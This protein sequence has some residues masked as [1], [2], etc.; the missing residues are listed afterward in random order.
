AAALDDEVDE[1]LERPTLFG[2]GVPPEG[3]ELEGAVGLH[4]ADPVEVLEPVRAGEGVAL[5]VVE[6][7]ARTGLGQGGQAPVGDH[8]EDR[9]HWGKPVIASL[10]LEAGL[11]AESLERGGA[12]AGHLD[13]PVRGGEGGEGA[14]AG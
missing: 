6:E 11:A 9:L 10:E 4:P 13:R 5:D 2:G 3:S 12:D 1:G 8:R 7:V 14:D